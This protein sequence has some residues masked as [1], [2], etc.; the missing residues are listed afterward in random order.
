MAVHDPL[1][2]SSMRPLRGALLNSG[3]KLKA[4][5]VTDAGAAAILD[6]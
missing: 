5:L 1:A 2:V 6:T 4:D 3:T